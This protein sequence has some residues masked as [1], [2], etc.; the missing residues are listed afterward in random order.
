VS[1]R[2]GSSSYVDWVPS[3]EPAVVDLIAARVLDPAE[4]PT[5]LPDRALVAPASAELEKCED[6]THRPDDDADQAHELVGH[7]EG[8][9]PTKNPPKTDGLVES[10]PPGRSKTRNPPCGGQIPHLEFMTNFYTT[11]PSMSNGI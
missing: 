11:A 6:Q 7:S 2:R 1:N 3:L 8:F 9:R 4:F 10:G 5:P